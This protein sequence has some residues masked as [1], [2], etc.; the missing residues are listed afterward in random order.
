MS[1]GKSNSKVGGAAKPNKVLSN[2]VK[3]FEKLTVMS[4]KL[5]LNLN[6]CLTDQSNEGS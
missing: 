5:Q 6:A 4:P 2:L 3:S 1:P